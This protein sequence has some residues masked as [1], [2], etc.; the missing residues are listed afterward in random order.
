MKKKYVI[1]TGGSQGLGFEICKTFL[2]EGYNI[3][4]C[5]KSK[6]NLQRAKKYFQ[7]KYKRSEII[8]IKCDLNSKKEINNFINRSK[9]YSKNLVALV[10]NA[11]VYGPFGQIEK[12]NFNNWVDCI[13]TNLIA[14]IYIISKVLPIFKKNKFGRIVNMSGGGA[15]SPLAKINAY[16]ASKAAFVRSSE[17][18]A[19][20]LDKKIDITINCVAPGA[21]KT[22]MLKQVLLK[23][24]KK[25]DKSFINK[26]R[27]VNI[28]GG[29]P[30]RL[31]ADLVYKLCQ[32]SNKLNGKLVSAVWDN[33]EKLNK[34]YYKINSSEKLTIKRVT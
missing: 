16:A 2:D 18:I 3:I 34:N 10:N 9:K 11:G 31:G 19:L 1:V 33:Y 26:M 22:Q 15:T 29:T 25:L 32:K 8:A 27:N 21:L 17:S 7:Q 23:G 5:G 20:E 24:N 30:L 13:N 14:P 12:I 4:F 6:S 28:S